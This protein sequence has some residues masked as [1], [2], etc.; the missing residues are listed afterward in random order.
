MRTRP[1]GSVRRTT[2][3]T[4]AKREARRRSKLSVTREGSLRV[5]ETSVPRALSCRIRR[6][7]RRRRSMSGA[8]RSP[9]TWGRTASSGVACSAEDG[10]G[11]APATAGFDVATGD[12]VPGRT[13]PDAAETVAVALPPS[14]LVTRTVPGLATP[15]NWPLYEPPPAFCSVP[16]S[17]P[18]VSTN[19]R[20]VAVA[21]VLVASTRS[22]RLA[23]SYC[24]RVMRTVSAA[25]ALGGLT[26]SVA[27]RVPALALVAVNTTGVDAVTDEVV[28]G[29]VLVVAPAGTVTVD[30]DVGATPGRSLVTV[31]SRPPAG[32]ARSSVSVPSEPLPPVTVDG[33]K[34]S[35]V[36]D[37]AGVAA[38]G[39]TA[40]VV[41]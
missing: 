27:L 7:R 17:A 28:I 1:A 38:A 24:A 23:G 8:A 32:A 34:P 37:A 16:M 19:A 35:D 18:V 33:L 29:K 36:S 6:G 22:W 41:D 40:I 20:S 11:A 2:P 5:S 3:G 21:L 9:A 31:K 26:V 15:S 25:G 4:A 10:L 13:V 30:G 39:T 14:E 12:V